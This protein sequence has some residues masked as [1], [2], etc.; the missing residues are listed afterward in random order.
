MDEWAHLLFEASYG[1]MKLDV[2]GVEDNV[3]RDV[4]VTTYPRRDGGHV[5][6][7]GAVPRDCRIVVVFFP[8]ENETTGSHIQRMAAFKA[9]LHDG[10]S[11]PFVHP[12]TGTFEAR[13][14]DIRLS[15]D[16]QERNWITMSVTFLE[17]SEEPAVFELGPGSP[18]RA[19]VEEV[20][21]AGVDLKSALDDLG[22]TST[23]ADD[24]DALAESWE[25]RADTISAREINLELNDLAN[26]IADATD[27]LELASDVA[28]YPTIQAFDRLRNNLR[29]LADTVISRSPQLISHGVTR[30]MPLMAIVSELYGDDDADTRYQQILELNDIRDPLRV[31]AGTTLTVQAPGSSDG[32]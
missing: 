16:A 12:L 24:A 5:D 30:T 8:Y 1:G 11:H 32:S 6:D 26:D 29:N 9:L 21:A 3:S 17:A 22:E 10:K 28:N 14:S 7:Q 2:V 23:I 19:G 27:E 20:L 4:V 13:P 31:E 25:E 15:A 18:V